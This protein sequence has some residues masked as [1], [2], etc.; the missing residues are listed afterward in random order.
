LP[1]H[2]AAQGIDDAAE[3]IHPTP[4]ASRTLSGQQ[5]RQ[6]PR[7]EAVKCSEWQCLGEAVAEAGD[8]RP[9]RGTVA[10][11]QQKLIAD[12]DLAR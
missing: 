8:L 6:L 10:T 5:R 12:E 9:D 7:P 3:P 4:R 1:V 2:R 11:I